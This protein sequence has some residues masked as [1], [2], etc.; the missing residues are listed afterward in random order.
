MKILNYPSTIK[1]KEIE[2]SINMLIKEYQDAHSSYIQSISL[3][4]YTDSNRWMD[5]LDKVNI[6]LKSKIKEAG[7]LLKNTIQKG[8][9]KQ[10]ITTLNAPKLIELSKKLHQQ[11]IKLKN[12]REKINDIDGNIEIT[13]LDNGGNYTQLFLYFIITI[14]VMSI[15]IISL[16][17]STSTLVDNV[18]LVMAII[19]IIYY[20][21]LKIINK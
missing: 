1:M 18:F 10:N 2:L 8:E 4:N 21:L 3:N 12:M 7:T 17:S 5:V 19:A 20:V 11:E 6:K 13:D 16:I 14:S 9:K 15:T